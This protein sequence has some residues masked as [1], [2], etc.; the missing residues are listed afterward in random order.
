MIGFVTDQP[1][2]SAILAGIEAAMDSRSIP[3]YWTTGSYPI[4][5]GPHAGSVFIPADDDLLA[6]PLMGNPPATPR[7]FPEFQQLVALLGGLENRVDID[8][9]DIVG[10]A[11]EIE[12]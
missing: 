4:L 5:F 12:P 8:P 1:T 7:D 6:T 2:A 9:A 11:L 3:R 10:Q